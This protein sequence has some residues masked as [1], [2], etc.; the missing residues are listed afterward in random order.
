MRDSCEFCDDGTTCFEGI[1]VDEARVCGKSLCDPPRICVDGECKRLLTLATY[2][3]YDLVLPGSTAG[4]ARY[5]AGSDIDLILFQEIQP[6]DAAGLVQALADEGVEMY[7]AFSSRGGYGG[8]RGNDYLAVFSRFPLT[9][10]E[11]IL[12]GTLRDP[13]TGVSFSFVYMRPVHRVVLT[14]H[15]R[16]LVIYNLHLKAQVP[17]P[18]CG[19][20]LARRR[21]QAAAL[22]TYILENDVPEL[23]H[24]IVAGDVNSALAADFEPGNTL[25]L[26]TLRSD[27]PE[28]T[29]NDFTPVNYLYRNE[30]TH[31]DFNS[32]LDHLI[33]SPALMPHYLP[34]SVRVIAP[35]GKPSD[36]KSV[37]LQLVF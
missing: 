6:E 33:L 20:C 29:G 12:G 18:D 1:C 15:D 24:V 35:A 14:V 10:H 19:D 25:D 13:V 21:A 37:L 27:N 3:L 28:N 8:D 22:E 36:H 16:E 2:N 7:H 30:S 5:I 31:L 34:D 9:G 11:T 26:L 17:F 4:V 23:D 32:L